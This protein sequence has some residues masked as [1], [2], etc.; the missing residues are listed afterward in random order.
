VIL[1]VGHRADPHVLAVAHSLERLQCRFAIIDAFH[2]HSDGLRHIITSGA[3][4]D[5]GT[6]G[7]PLSDCSSIWWR[8]KPKFTMPADAAGLYD[9]YFVHRE[10]NAI[11][12]YLC[13]EATHA[14]SINDRSGTTAANNKLSQLKIA[15]ESGFD[16][17]RTLISNNPDAIIEFV[18]S[19]RPN[20]CIFKPFVPYMPPSGTITYATE[21]DVSRLLSDRDRLRV[22]P[23]IFQVFVEKQFE[24]RI[25]IVGNDVFAARINSK[26]SEKA[27]VDWR[28]EIFSDI[29]TIYDLEPDFHE[30]L[31]N[32]HRRFGLY[33]AAYDFIIDCAG[34]PIFLEVNPSGQWMWLEVKLGFPI[35]ERIALALAA[36]P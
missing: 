28:Q 31:L 16:I 3:E 1:I 18:S 9:Y 15:V 34:N 7:V 10:W 5:I 32:L 12:D 19:A 6:S 36:A 2:E 27:E 20:R 22:A 30:K 24:L 33:F 8:Q 17:P 29:Y 13:A 26:H 25:T 21:I 4:L 35:A 23:G 14:F 11:I